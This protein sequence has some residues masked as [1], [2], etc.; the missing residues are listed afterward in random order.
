M[1]WVDASAGSGGSVSADA[2]CLPAPQAGRE[3]RNSGLAVHSSRIGASLAQSATW[4]IASS[5]AGS[6]QWTSSHTA[7]TGRSLARI[8]KNRR[9][10]H[11]VSSGAE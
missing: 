5:S 11:A 6:A 1:S 3:S 10:A 2:R 4:S 7:I 9:I 8:S